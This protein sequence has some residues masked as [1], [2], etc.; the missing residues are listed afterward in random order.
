M[1]LR[2]LSPLRLPNTKNL[3]FRRRVP[4]DMIEFMGTKEIRFSLDT[5]DEDEARLLVQEHNLQCERLWRSHRERRPLDT[6][7]QREAAA[8]AGEFY[9]EWVGKH[10]DFPGRPSDWEKSIA[11]TE[12]R[13][14]PKI[15]F[16]PLSQWRMIAF[17]TEARAFLA[18][19]DR[20]VDPKSLDLFIQAFIGAKVQ[21]EKH[22]QR[23]AGGDYRP[24]PDAD[25]FPPLPNASEDRPAGKRPRALATF[26]AYAAAAKLSPATQKRWKKIIEHLVAKLGHDDLARL[27]TDDLIDWKNELLPRLDPDTGKVVS[28]L[29]P[30]TVRDVYVAAVKATLQYAKDERWL[31]SNVA[32]GVKVRVP[33][34]PREREKGFVKTEAVAILRKSLT[35]PSDKISAEM[36][37]ARR[38]IPWMLA[39][40]GAR[41][42]EITPITAMNFG[43]ERGIWKLRITAT[44]TKTKEY[45]DVPVHDHLVEQGLI[46]YMKSRGSKPLFYDPARSRG[47]SDG[48]PHYKKVGERM[49]EWVGTIVPDVKTGKVQP[50]HG[51]RHRF[52]SLAREVGMHVDVQNIIQG[53]VGERTAESYGDAW[54]TTAYREIMKLPRYKV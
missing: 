20:Q 6:L 47:G 42:N 53:H 39:Y 35:P 45:R 27:T 48:N 37:A 11:D 51:W 50:N 13:K 10:R 52:S 22:L 23:M 46:E 17:G 28:G 9:R 12:R 18:T 41:V 44:H 4:D 34:K 32:I 1:G 54:L 25:R 30:V 21:A 33:K 8:L 24:D 29:D 14:A 40:S 26:G 49:A 19:R 16:G 31:P 3:W 36:A 43:R 7:T 15:W 5:T 38:W 2:M